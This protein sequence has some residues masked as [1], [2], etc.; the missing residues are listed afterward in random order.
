MR[1]EDMQEILEARPFKPFRLHLTDGEAFD[2]TH[3]E[4]VMQTRSKLIV[5]LPPRQ[6]SRIVEHVE[7]CALM[8]VVRVEELEAGTPS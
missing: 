5:D 2:I 6:G 1:A 7:H 3:P 8:H 4:L